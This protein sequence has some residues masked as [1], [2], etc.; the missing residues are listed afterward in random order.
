MRGGPCGRSAG[1]RAKR[2]ARSRASGWLLIEPHLAVNYRPALE[3]DHAA[4]PTVIGVWA[5]AGAGASMRAWN[6]LSVMPVHQVESSSKMISRLPYRRS[7]AAAVGKLGLPPGISSEE[8]SVS[9][10]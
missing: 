9:W 2:V 8:W 1:A 10:R 5:G 6:S 3:A 7:M 4:A